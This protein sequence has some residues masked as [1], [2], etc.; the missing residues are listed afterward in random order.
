MSLGRRQVLLGGLGAGLA[1]AAGPRL[2]AAR[3]E[4]ASPQAFSTYGIF[5]GGGE[6]DQ[7]A[8]LQLAADQAAASGTP[9]FLPAGVYS[10]SPLELK[11]G[12]QIEGVPGST[13]LRY[14]DGETILRLA[15]VE[16]VRLAGLVLDGQNLNAGDG[17]ALLAAAEVKHLDLSGC[18]FIASAADGIVLR[19]VSG[20]IRNCE[21][22]NVRKAGLF[23]ED[24]GGLEIADNH[25]HDCG[26]NGILVWRSAPGEDGT[27]VSGNRIERIAA[28]SGGS[29]QNGNGINVFRAGSVLIS[30]N[31]IAD[32]AFSAIRANSGSNCQMVGNSCARLGEVALYA[33]F[34]FEGAVIANNLVDKAAIG[35]SVTNYNEGGRLAV[36]QGNLIRNLFPRKDA[37]TR[38][39]GIHVEADTVVT[40]NVIEGSP[41]FGIVIGWGPYLRD[42]SVTDNLVRNAYIGIGVSTDPAAGTA[43]ITNNLISGAKDGAIRA[44]SG[45]T[46][47]GPDLARE[48][49]DAYGN[50]AVYANVSRS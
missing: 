48:K 7:T 46:P 39:I 45:P 20:W 2:A 25:V 24:A 8:T 5:P 31:R 13:V 1:A 37:E 15:G 30:G 27:I 29:G 4:T 44:M 21:I 17:N 23:S 50:L 19:R 3:D 12:T 33:E 32:C 40:G 36:V 42:V 34:A 43:L 22:A 28:K 26:D 14:R 35:V 41:A 18:R 10:T 6:I 49:A 38:G 9:L 47:V 11:S 16:N